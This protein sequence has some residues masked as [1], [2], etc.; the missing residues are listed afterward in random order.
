M[1]FVPE[2]PMTH[3]MCDKAVNRCF[4]VFDSIPNQYITQEMCNNFISEDPFSIRYVP[5]QYKTQQMCDK[6]VDDCLSA[7]KFVRDRFVTSKMIRKH[8][9]ALYAD[10]NILYTNVTFCCNEMRILSVNL[11]NINLDNT[12]YEEHDPDTIILIRL[13]A[14]HMKL[15][16]WKTQST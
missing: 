6:A 11:N 10:E 15:G 2:C 1:K 12:N 16:I 7:T 14:W 5:D 9:T 4:F 8:F 3:K 13:L